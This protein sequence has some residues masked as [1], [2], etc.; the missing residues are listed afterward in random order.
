MRA[1]ISPGIAAAVR[2]G[3]I[4]ICATAH[5]GCW[6]AQ[7]RAQ[8]L[9]Q[10]AVDAWATP[11][12]KDRKARA[13]MAGA[14]IAEGERVRTGRV[15]PPGAG[16]RLE[17][18]GSSDEEDE[19]V[20]PVDPPERLAVSLLPGVDVALEAESAMDV[21]LLRFKKRVDEVI[22]REA[23]IVFHRGALFVSLAAPEGAVPAS[24]TVET[25]AGP[26][27]ASAGCLFGI[28]ADNVDL[29]S[30]IRVVCA[31]GEVSWA[32][33][34]LPA[35]KVIKKSLSTSSRQQPSARPDSFSTTLSDAVMDAAAQRQ[36]ARLRAAERHLERLELQR[37]DAPPAWRK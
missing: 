31:R 5:A 30:G 28:W 17:A 23:A 26:L 11:A 37:Q 7:V 21:R 33:Q 1:T 12:G 19:A 15:Q 4:V 36:I 2:M 24:L 13:L 10:T 35:G 8:V 22:A 29:G 9:A 32:G 6:R 34:V 3:L 16:A 20:N 14:L 25:R 27:R 18:G